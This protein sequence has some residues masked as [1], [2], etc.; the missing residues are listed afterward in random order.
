MRWQPFAACAVLALAACGKK[1]ET[2]AVVA[3]PDMPKVAGAYGHPLMSSRRANVPTDTYQVWLFKDC[4]NVTCENATDEYGMVDQGHVAKVCPN[5][6]MMHVLLM[7]PESTA[8]T[9]FNIQEAGSGKTAA[10]VQ[11][12]IDFKS[13][14]ADGI[15]LTIGEAA[16]NAAW[17]VN[18]AKGTFHAPMC[19]ASK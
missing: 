10:A 3:Y 4:P 15:D 2:A 1:D 13:A 18:N 11:G 17:A 16:G 9:S 8:Q 7:K 19:K 6:L 5:G 12:K 14:T